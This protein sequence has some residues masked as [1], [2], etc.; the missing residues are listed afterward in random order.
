MSKITSGQGREIYEL[1]TSTNPKMSN[2]EIGKKYG[3]SERAVRFH[4]KKYEKIVHKI[5]QNNSKVNKVL[6]AHQINII[7]EASLL[8]AVVKSGIQQARKQGVSPEKIS[9]L[10]NNWIRALEIISDIQIIKR[11][12]ALEE[13]AKGGKKP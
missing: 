11:I 13:A 1:A 2:V 6:A 7:E 10:Y 3:I 12:E 9:S 8:L 5:S 4:I